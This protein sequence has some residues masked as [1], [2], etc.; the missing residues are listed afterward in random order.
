VTFATGPLSNLAPNLV[1]TGAVRSVNLDQLGGELAITC[2]AWTVRGEAVYIGNDGPGDTRND[3]YAYYGEVSYFVTGEQREYNGKRGTYLGVT[4]N[5]EL[6]GEGGG[7]GAIELAARFSEIDLDSG[8]VQG[9]KLNT[10]TGG[11]NWYFYKHVRLMANYTF[12]NLQGVG[13]AD[14]VQFRLQFAF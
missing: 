10:I 2:G 5:N 4:P 1:N 11:V 7:Y 6:F 14:V 3:F 13:N 8:Q 12:A 9:G